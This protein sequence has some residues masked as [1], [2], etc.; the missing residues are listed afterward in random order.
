MHCT[1]INAQNG[2]EKIF[3]RK[4]LSDTAVSVESSVDRNNDTVDKTGGLFV[5]QELQGTDQVFGGT[6]FTHRGVVDDLV[7]A[8]G[9]TAVSIG[10]HLK[11]MASH[12]FLEYL[13][14]R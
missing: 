10:Q 5:H 4:N 1:K 11:K 13:A 8:G 7:A 14:S 2:S 12:I 3:F 6:E 9:Q